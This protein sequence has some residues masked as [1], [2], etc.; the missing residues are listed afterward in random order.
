MSARLKPEDRGLRIDAALEELIDAAWDRM[1]RAPTDRE[2]QDA[3]TEV[4]VLMRRRSD[5]Q[6]LKF[7]FERRALLR[8]VK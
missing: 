6:W 1:K 5:T 8:A 3:L 7:E 2:S 4:A